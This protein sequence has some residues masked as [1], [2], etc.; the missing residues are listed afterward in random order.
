MT[1]DQLSN[2]TWK[3]HKKS[4]MYS[5]LL[6]WKIKLP[7]HEITAFWVIKLYFLIDCDFSGIAFLA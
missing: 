4:M 3:K 7:K 5:K 1:V 6:S 2:F